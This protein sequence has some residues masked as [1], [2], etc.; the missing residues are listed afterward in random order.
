M[1][2]DNSLAEAGRVQAAFA[3]GHMPWRS[4]VVAY[5]ARMVYGWKD[6]VVSRISGTSEYWIR[7]NG[8]TERI[9]VRQVWP[10]ASR[11]AASIAE[12]ADVR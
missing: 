9:R 10:F 11:H 4:S 7:P 3:A 8:G 1:W 5:F 12:I 6:A 2:P